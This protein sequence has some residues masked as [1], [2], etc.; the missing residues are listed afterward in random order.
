MSPEFQ[1]GDF[2][3]TTSLLFFIKHIKAGDVI[4]FEHGLYGL[5]IKRVLN[6][7]NDDQV[8]VIGAN[9]NSLDSR[10]LGPVKRDTVRGKVLWRISK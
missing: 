6:F 9:E 5:L 4:V 2:I 7:T 3:I 1:E 10:R 8:Y